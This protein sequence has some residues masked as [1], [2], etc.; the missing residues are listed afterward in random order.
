MTIQLFDLTTDKEVCRL[1]GRHNRIRSVTFSPDGQML[2]SGSEDEVV[3]LWSI[4]SQEIVREFKGHK[5]RILSVA[6]SPDGKTLASGGEDKSIRLWNVATGE[7]LTVWQQHGDWIN[8]LAFSPDNKMVL[9]GSQDQ[10][11]KLWNRETNYV[12][13]TLAG[14][15]GGIEGAAFAPDGKTVVSASWDRNIF[16]WDVASGQP[17]VKLGGN[18]SGVKAVIFSNDGK[19]LM[20]GGGDMVI[21]IWDLA[22]GR[23]RNMT[24]HQSVV[25]TLALAADDQTLVSGSDDRTLRLW[26]VKLGKEVRVLEESGGLVSAVAISPDGK[27]VASINHGYYSKIIKLPA[28]TALPEQKPRAAPSSN[29][30]DQL[31]EDLAAEE[32]NTAYGAARAFTAAPALAIPFFKNKVH[33]VAPLSSVQIAKWLAALRGDS[34]TAQEEAIAALVALGNRVESNLRQ[35]LVNQAPGEARDRMQ[36]VLEQVKGKGSSTDGLR[37]LRVISILMRISNPEARQLMQALSQGAP[38]AVLTR[39]AQRGMKTL[40]GRGQGTGK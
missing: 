25:L 37:E 21:R 28:S 12:V 20:T 32:P 16:L 8:C 24:G 39:E 9:S 40:A 18:I 3:H 11:L 29:N 31:W 34:V 19:Y 35:A 10:T 1:P 5:G 30:L 23:T 7:E 38:D 15:T 33:P 4:E 14:H 36:K 17:T 26:N 2:V 6:F 27:T 13:F 22:T